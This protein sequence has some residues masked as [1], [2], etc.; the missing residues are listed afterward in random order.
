[1]HPVTRIDVSHQLA[2]DT[3]SLLNHTKSSDSST[4]TD[5]RHQAAVP[6]RCH[7]PAAHACSTRV[8][9][10]TA[11][12]M[13]RGHAGEHRA[14]CDITSARDVSETQHGA[15]ARRRRLVSAVVATP[16]QEDGRGWTGSTRGWR[17]VPSTCIREVASIGCCHNR[18]LTLTAANCRPGPARGGVRAPPRTRHRAHATAPR[19]RTVARD[20]RQ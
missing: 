13:L 5:S 15:P 6:R 7:T 14:G 18:H 11:V 16:G 8:F 4:P 9:P 20:C 3:S 1:M 17:P 19:V 10:R 12:R 2:V